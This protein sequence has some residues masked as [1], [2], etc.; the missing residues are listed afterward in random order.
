MTDGWTLDGLMA[1]A[2]LLVTVAIA[3]GLLESTVMAPVWVDLAAMAIALLVASWAV[4][5]ENDRCTD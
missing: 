1:A 4:Q 3:A 5:A 2:L